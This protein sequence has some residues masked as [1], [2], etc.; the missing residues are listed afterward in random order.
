MFIHKTQVIGNYFKCDIFKGGEFK[1]FSRFNC[2]SSDFE[3]M[4]KRRFTEEDAPYWQFR[5][6]PG[7][8]PDVYQLKPQAYYEGRLSKEAKELY[9]INL[10]AS[11][12]PGEDYFSYFDVP[13]E[14]QK[15]LEE[16]RAEVTRAD[17][18]D[19]ESI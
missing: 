6:K 15:E 7:R 10:D 18:P 17:S 1:P 3:I 19:E 5:D 8:D 9:D 4:M 13:P 16:R 14:V 11:A 2:S 12:T